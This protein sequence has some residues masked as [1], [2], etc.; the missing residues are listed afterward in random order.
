MKNFTLVTVLSGI[1]LSGFLF[2]SCEK[3][4]ADTNKSIDAISGNWSI[5]RVQVKLY[6]SG[7]FL[8]DSILSNGGANTA[9]FDNS[10]KVFTYKYKSAVPETGTYTTKGADSVIAVS[11]IKTYR[12]KMLTLTDVLF[13][14][15]STSTNDPAF[16]GATVETYYT[17]VK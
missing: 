6:Y 17:F 14:A 5:N 11:N 3:T 16:P 1:L 13:T 4:E 12:W 7:V 15:R 9:S 2:S 10:T 8:K